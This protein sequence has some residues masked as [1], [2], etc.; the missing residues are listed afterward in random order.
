MG[1]NEIRLRRS[2]LTGRG[3]ERFRNYGA[4]L[5]QHEKEMRLKKIVR[6]FTYL[7]VILIVIALIFFISQV[8]RKAIEKKSFNT[9]KIIRLNT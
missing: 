6:V 4:V 1:R 7:L 8:E 5:E 9:E 3:S 2:R